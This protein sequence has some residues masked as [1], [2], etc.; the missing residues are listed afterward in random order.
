L[1]PETATP[2]DEPLAG[3]PVGDTEMFSGVVP[4]IPPADAA[5]GRASA[6]KVVIA[7][8]DRIT[9]LIS[10]GHPAT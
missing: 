10:T 7:A 6:K 4:K 8:V 3:A 1:S 2:P 9:H 5:P